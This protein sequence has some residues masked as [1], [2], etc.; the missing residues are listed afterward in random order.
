MSNPKSLREGNV[1]NNPVYIDINQT[2]LDTIDILKSKRINFGIVIKDGKS[3]V[4]II[5]LKQIFDKIVLKKFKD[6]DLRVHIHLNKHVRNDE[7][8]EAV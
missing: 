1:I 6:K 5:T 2:L 7:V 3:C 8:L 4:G